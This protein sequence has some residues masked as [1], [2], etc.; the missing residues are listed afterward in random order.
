MGGSY[1]LYGVRRLGCG[2]LG[3]P[4]PG[5]TLLTAGQPSSGVPEEGVKRGACGGLGSFSG[6]RFDWARRSHAS[7]LL[8]ARRGFDCREGR[9]FRFRLGKSWNELKDLVGAGKLGVGLSRK[10]IV[11]RN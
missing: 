1:G 2:L 10:V 5:S 8:G 4:P 11:C 3:E 7:A 6:R 9:S